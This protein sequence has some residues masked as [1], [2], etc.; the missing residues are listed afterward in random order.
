MQDTGMTETDTQQTDE[1]R[2]LRQILG[3][4]GFFDDLP[5]RQ[6]M[7]QDIWS[8]GNLADFVASPSSMDALRRT[9]SA[10]HER[11]IPLNPRGGGMSYTNGY[12]P[13][14]AGTGILDLSRMNRILEINAEDMYVTL[15]AGVT[16]K[17][18]HE[19]LAPL[20]LRTPFWGPLSG[21][22]ST[23]GG[24]LSQN[25]AFFGAGTHGPST[26]SVI[27]LS[28]VLADG[29]LLRTGTAGTQG[30]KPFW[31]HYGPDLAGLFLGDAGAFGIK[32]E[33][34]L[35]LIKAPEHEDWATFEFADRD[36]C[37]RAMAAIAR[38]GMACEVF[39]FDPKLTAVRLKR[40]SLVSDTKALANVIKAQGSLLKGLAEGAKVALAG[41]GFVE[42][43]RW[44]VNFV[45]EGRSRQGVMDNMRYLK[46]ICAKLGGIETENS[47]PKIIRAN[48]FT[49]LNNSLGPE[50]ER[51]VPVHGIVPLSEGAQVWAEIDALFDR[52][53]GD[54]EKHRIQTGF[55]VTTLST[56]G[57][58]IEPVFLW[59][60]EIHEIH[61]IAVEKS[62]LG[63]LPR[64]RA[65]PEATQIVSDARK[66]VI[67]IFSSH[68]GAHFQIGRSYPYFQG[69]DADSRA[70]LERLKS[71]VDPD[72]LIN[73]GALGLG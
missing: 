67:E 50:G 49:P 24:G 38:E 54:F 58:L 60:E 70:F 28:V 35:R 73:P 26:E 43:N 72:R 59:P 7:S 23:I 52:M 13:D 27:S 2:I 62:W 15:E 63:R 31:R 32:A 34:T 29:S 33:V 19:A 56:N 30:A 68:G 11:R 6:L 42:A 16:W 9:V 8:K 1:Y 46:A 22:S 25:N 10:C 4:D 48:P 64:H 21:I 47:I 51:W 57:Y 37:A 12:T 5:T 66:K 41:R 20:G 61:E 45:V 44:S 69:R 17:A 65:N 55:L 18:L 3:A 39:G 36:T 53:R 71:L 14:R 40:A